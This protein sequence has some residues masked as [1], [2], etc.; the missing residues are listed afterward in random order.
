M[1]LNV[2]TYLLSCLKIS[3]LKCFF[4]YR[5]YLVDCYMFTQLHKNILVEVLFCLQ[6][7]FSWLLVSFFACREYLVGCQLDFIVLCVFRFK[8]CFV[9]K[10]TVLFNLPIILLWRERTSDMHVFCYCFY[11]CF[12]FL[13]NILA[14]NI[15]LYL[16]FRISCKVL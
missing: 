8:I 2:L 7:I 14:I 5:E 6:R 13:M 4:A 10:K 3:Q 9:K 12:V 11:L 1:L 15:C 16:H